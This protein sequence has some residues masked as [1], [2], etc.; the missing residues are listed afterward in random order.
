MTYTPDDAAPTDLE[1]RMGLESLEALHHE[2]REIIRQL[3]PLKLLYGS[4][5]DR[6]DAKR[7]QHRDVIGK[8]LR[9]ELPDGKDLPQN[10]I[11]AMANSDQRHLDFCDDLDEKFIK[12]EYWTN[13]LNEVD[14]RIAARE[15][16]SRYI[17]KEL[18][19]PQ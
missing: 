9:Q 2:R 10:R 13:C 18:G 6:A 12:F 8:L 19:M 5:G 14:E 16:L 7:E 17:T 4:G 3:T 11:E 15:Y 1:A